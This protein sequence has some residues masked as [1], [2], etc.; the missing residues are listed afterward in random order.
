MLV[1]CKSSLNNG[2][3]P[4]STLPQLAR[5]RARP[6]P[7]LASGVRVGGIGDG[8]REEVARPVGV[9][10][11]SIAEEAEFLSAEC[12]WR[13]S[14]IEPADAK[15][16]VVVVVGVGLCRTSELKYIFGS[17]SFD[18]PN[19]YPRE[20]I[21]HGDS[22]VWTSA[23]DL[24]LRGILAVDFSDMI[25]T[26]ISARSKSL[27]AQFVHRLSQ[28]STGEPEFFWIMIL[29]WPL[30]HPSNITAPKVVTTVPSIHLCHKT[31]VN[32]TILSCS[33]HSLLWTPPLV[34]HPCN[35]GDTH[36]QATTDVNLCLPL[37]FY[38][39]S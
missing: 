23:K 7:P 39:S 25:G 19:I 3:F 27:L 20:S 34:D 30:R 31:D 14:T 6:S 38:L 32:H 9:W 8:G 16:L 1:A 10:V 28:Q 4:A 35:A 36:H 24:P 18:H 12:W 5:L 26:G 11:R 37:F 21:Y 29:L 22:F 2:S 13:V 15:A 17:A 33:P